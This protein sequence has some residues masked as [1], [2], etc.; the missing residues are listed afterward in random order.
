MNELNVPGLD[1]PKGNPGAGKTFKFRVRY[2]NEKARTLLGIE[3]RNK[4]TI[5]KDTVAD[6]QARGW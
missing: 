5:A 3:F 2:N 1:V 4:L 6:I